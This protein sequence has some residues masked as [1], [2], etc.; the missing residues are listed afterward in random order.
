M[1]WYDT[2]TCGLHGV[3]VLIQYQVDDEPIKLHSVWTTPIQETLS[4][5]E[6]MMDHEGGLVGFNLA[7]DHFHLCKIYNMLSLWHNYD[8]YPIDI[9]EDLA[10]L[11]PKAMDGACLK[12]K[13][14]LDLMLHA[15]KGEYQSTM[16]RGDINI[17]RVPTMLAYSLAE[18]LNELIPLNPIYFM[19]SKNG[20]QWHV[21]DI[22][23]D[24]DFKTV[25][26]KFA[27]SS[28]LKA[29]AVDIGLVNKN[30]V[31]V[32]QDV[33]VE[34]RHRP[35]EYGYAPYALAG[36]WND[37]GVWQQ[38]YRGHWLNTWVDKVNVHITHW[39]YNQQ[40][41]EYAKT[42]VVYTRK[43][44]EHFMKQGDMH[45]DDD[46]SVLACMVGSVR[47]HGFK[48][49]IEKMTELKAKVQAIAESLPFVNA[50]KKVLMYVT[51]PMDET[52][53][54]FIDSTKKTILEDIAKW[55]K[56]DPNSF[57]PVMI[58]HPSAL[59]AE[60][61]LICRQAMKEVELYDKLL[62]AGRFCPSFKVIGTLSTRMSGAD[63][64]N[65][66]GIKHDKYVRECFPLNFDPRHYTLCG[67]DF[68]S[69]E[70]VLAD[71]E[72]NDPNLHKDL[73]IGKSIHALFGQYVFLDKS[74]D[75]IRA[76]K[77]IYTK[78]KQ[79]VFALLY[80]GEAETLKDRLGVDLEVA[81]EA[82]RRFTSVY[83]EVGKARRKVFDMFCSMRQPNGLGTKVEWHEPADYIESLF[84]FRRYFTL[85]NKICKALFDLAETPPK[86]WTRLKIT[87]TRRDREQSVSGAVR[88]AL[89]GAAFA[90]Q[91]GAMRAACNHRIQSSGAQITKRVQRRIWDMQPAGIGD[92]IVAPLNIHDEILTPVRNDK[93]MG[94]K[95]I[96][97]QT[98]ESFRPR[99]PLIKMEWKVGLK[100]WAEK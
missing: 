40:A 78:C 51:E 57:E 58:R 80:G 5:I 73:L 34:S 79:A 66:Q 91:A 75:E 12:P 63:G 69:F 81:N 46:D 37:R 90:I 48:V 9:I 87:V 6:M 17:N 29:L 74:Y 93:V 85:E 8:D 1:I 2:E 50:P 23:D 59:R 67:G 33:E 61:V 54:A 28:A 22:E 100:S 44:Y 35:V 83:T 16:D 15:R 7:F 11:E 13:H 86:E 53:K 19:R 14:C 49:D 70:V 47:W 56:N 97:N 96:V 65:P 89:F 68:D 82:Y 45:M 41:R 24:V 18:K 42:D 32:Y 39:G 20:V 71:A 72:Y 76:D 60:E 77:A 4:L 88:S 3:V 30:D 55:E 27:P 38:T 92:W 21:L 10:M 25:T 99:V 98:V 95:D 31:T 26:L 94:V 62:Q 52:E 84:G 64:L 36:V 43:L